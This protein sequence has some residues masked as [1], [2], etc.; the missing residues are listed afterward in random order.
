MRVQIYDTYEE[1]SK[2]AADLVAAQL[3]Q[4]PNCHLGLTAGK[5]PVGLCA[6][7]VKLYKEHRVS[8]AECTLYNLEEMADVGPEDPKNLRNSF[9][10]AH[11]LDFVDADDKQLLLPDGFADGIDEACRK[12]DELMDNLP[13]GRLDMQVLGIGEDAHIGMN[14]PN[15]TLIP[16]AHVVYNK[17]G[18]PTCAMGLRHILLSKRII[19]IA[20]GEEKAEAVA[21]M[22]HGQL[23]T[24]APASLLQ[25]HPD[26]V[27]LLDK[28]AASK[29]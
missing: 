28:P 15:E 8:F 21:K 5:T 13:D 18:R 24:M 22:C 1:M 4:K 10:H 2:A 3:L 16:E 29:L 27:V 6:E 20:N 19:M 17:A 25:V 23:T 26:V 9:F 11:L 12:Y 7:L 14:R